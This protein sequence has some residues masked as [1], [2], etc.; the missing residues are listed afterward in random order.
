MNRFWLLIAPALLFFYAGLVLTIMIWYP[1]GLPQQGWQD[2]LVHFSVIYAIWL[3]VL[4]IYTLFDLATFRSTLLVISRLLGAMLT[5]GII[6]VAYFYFQPE[7]ILTPRRFLVVHL[8]ITTLGLAL[9]Y[10]LI[11]NILPRI[12]KKH[13]YLHPLVY[14]QNLHVGIEQYLDVHRTLGWRFAGRYDLDSLDIHLNRAT[15][16]LPVDFSLNDSELRSLFEHKR[17]GVEFLE[18][19]KFI[20]LTQR[21]VPL[22]KVSEIW[23]LRSVNYAPRRLSDA[24]KRVLD[25]VVGALGSLL[26]AILLPF[27]FVI[28][29]LDSTGPVFFVQQ[30]IGQGGKPFNV[31]KLRTMTSG[32][33]TDIWTQEQ[34]KRITRV[35]KFLRR[36]RVDELPQ[37]W[38]IF[39]G[40]MS[41]V[42]PRPEQ[43]AIVES[44][45]EQIPYYNERH[46]V[47]PGLTGWSQLH[48][49]A[50]SVEGTRL[51]LQYD[52]YYIKHRSLW[53]DLEIIL[54]TIFHILSL[55][56][57]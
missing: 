37:F 40:N 43:T 1:G 15:V 3:V 34:D 45:V 51:K 49:Y 53:F 32:S 36:L 7:L 27:L 19:H 5:C 57:R 6:A 35:G 56:G 41:L 18:Y 8:L 30:R 29:K 46:I 44:L 54:R 42:G 48:V 52:F 12:W 14:E 38:N 50:N 10:S 16:I 33:P 25:L 39:L 4:F 23:F 11:Q 24:I 2:H 22:E 47:K 55:Q 13:L 20:E 31:F 21:M 28:I 26:L 9:W 17:Q